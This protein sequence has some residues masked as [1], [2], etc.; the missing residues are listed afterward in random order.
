VRDTRPLLA[1]RI[2]HPFQ[3]FKSYAKPGIKQLRLAAACHSNWIAATQ[4]LE[5][6]LVGVHLTGEGC[7]LKGCIF[8]EMQH[9]GSR[10][11]TERLIGLLKRLKMPK[12]D[13]FS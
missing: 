5:V 3:Y 1:L 10:R 6:R 4:I 13:N 7:V 9:P 12:K 2:Q 11:D 8:P